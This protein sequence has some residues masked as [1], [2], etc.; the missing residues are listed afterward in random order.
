MAH[1]LYRGISDI[2]LPTATYVVAGCLSGKK[3]DEDSFRFLGKDDDTGQPLIVHVGH[4]NGLTVV[5]TFEKGF[6]D[7]WIK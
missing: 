5:S 4:S 7:Q 3:Y 1:W 2:E 6:Y